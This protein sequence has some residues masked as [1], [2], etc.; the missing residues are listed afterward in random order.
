M[1][2]F[3]SLLLLVALCGTLFGCKQSDLPIFEV[4]RSVTGTCGND[5]EMFIFDGN[6]LLDEKANFS[7][8]VIM[9]KELDITDKNNYDD[10]IYKKYSYKVE[11]TGK[12]N[13]KFSTKAIFVHLEFSPEYIATAGGKTGT[14]AENG[15]FSYTYTFKS[16]AILTEWTP[17]RVTI[18]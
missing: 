2:R 8:K 5:F 13:S 4:G 7:I 11:I 17:Y 18:R 12:A 9:E 15:D 16:N 3:F 10:G 1:K 6:T 14:I